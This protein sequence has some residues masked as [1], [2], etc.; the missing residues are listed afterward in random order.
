MKFGQNPKISE[1]K[2]SL[3]EKVQQSARETG[4]VPRMKLKL[5]QNRK[6][7]SADRK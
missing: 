1:V 5:K 2:K 4:S 3:K 6:W 7:S